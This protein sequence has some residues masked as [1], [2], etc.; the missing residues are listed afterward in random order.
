MR[1]EFRPDEDE[2]LGS[3]AEPDRV[4]AGHPRAVPQKCRR[5]NRHQRE[6]DA[7]QH[8]RAEDQ[9]QDEQRSV[10]SWGGRS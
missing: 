9:P 7:R 5:A 3:R 4:A 10:P 8:C 6:K 1:E 2:R